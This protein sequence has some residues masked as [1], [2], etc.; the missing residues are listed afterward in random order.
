MDAVAFVIVIAG[1]RVETVDEKGNTNSC[2][3]PSIGHQNCHDAFASALYAKLHQKSG[4]EFNEDGY[5]DI[6]VDHALSDSA[7]VAG[8]LASIQVS[9]KN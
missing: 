2:G 5:V 6:S 7:V 8:V 3:F 9:T 4:A 1:W